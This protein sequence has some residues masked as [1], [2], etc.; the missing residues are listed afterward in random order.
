MWQRLGFAVWVVLA[1]SCATTPRNDVRGEETEARPAV[2][3]VTQRSEGVLQLDFEPLPL[4]PTWEWLSTGEARAVLAAFV[5]SV[6]E[7]PGY[8]V[9]PVIAGARGP[10]AEWERRLRAEF[11]ARY[12]PPRLPMP[13]SIERSPL[14]MAL[15][16]SP[17]HMGPGFRDAAE[18]LFR[19]PVFLASVALSIVV[20][21]AAWLLPEPLFSKAFAA[22]LTARLALAVGLVELRR[23]ALACLQLYREAQS[24]RSLRELEFVAERFGR[25]TGGTALRVLVT[26][27]SFGVA[28]TL[29]NVPPGGLGAL[30][31][32][33]RFAVAGGLS[34]QGATTAHV[35]ADGTLVIAGAVVGTAASTV[36]SACT[37]G[38]EKKDGYQWHHLATDKNDTSATRGGPWTP[39]FR[40]LFARAGMDLDDPANRVY[41]A[42]HRGPHP[43]EYHSVVHDLLDAVLGRCRSREECRRDLLD[44]LRDIA[45]QVCTP[46]TQLHRLVVR[47]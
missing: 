10:A 46:G 6:P 16:L 12:G 28:R 2:V 30:L 42:G 47:P 7:R 24:A 40:R 45:S 22:T 34:F 8:E 41:L 26:V 21:F 36:G 1:A 9:V 3:A 13:D 11:V 18:E 15:R 23:V 4:A 43:E 17:R 29:P 27:A 37:D 33:P 20:Y 38:A 32:P 5:H 25:A 39:L 35:V 14:Y 19:S 31:S 44:A